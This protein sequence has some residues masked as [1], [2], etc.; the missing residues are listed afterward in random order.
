MG[1]LSV[2]ADTSLHRGNHLRRIVAHSILEY[3]GD[4]TNHTR[5]THQVSVEDNKVSQLTAFDRAELVIDSE[6]LG[7]IGRHD[8]NRLHRCETGLDEKLIVALIT[9]T[10]EGAADAGRVH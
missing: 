8:L 6:D 4:L 7:T 2:N 5:V 3:G 9:E 1:N 10:C